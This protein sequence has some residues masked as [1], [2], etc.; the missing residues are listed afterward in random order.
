MMSVGA[1]IVAV[2]GER[3][4]SQ[5]QYDA[6]LTKAGV[7]DELASPI[8]D[9]LGEGAKGVVEGQSQSRPTERVRIIGST[10]RHR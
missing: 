1:Y 9:A 5:T 6:A 10:L 4:H 2:N 8:R 7:L 3:I